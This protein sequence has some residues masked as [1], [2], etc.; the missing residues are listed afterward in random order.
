MFIKNVHM[1][2]PMAAN[3]APSVITALPVVYRGVRRDVDG[4]AM[5]TIRPGRQHA[6]QEAPEAPDD[7]PRLRGLLL[8]MVI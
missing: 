1:G 3:T 7:N 6:P 2:L 8:D 4:P 5:V